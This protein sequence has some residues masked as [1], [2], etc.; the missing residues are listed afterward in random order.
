MGTG[1]NL[2]ALAAKMHR[3]EVLRV[4]LRTEG[5]PAPE[6]PLMS[7][8]LP[9][10]SAAIVGNIEALEIFYVENDVDINAQGLYARFTALHMACQTFQCEAAAW[11]VSHGA[12]E[13]PNIM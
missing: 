12:V 1:Y 10:Y 11:L 4:L 13:Q 2:L 3:N 9:S 5:A 8:Q 7:G 6:T